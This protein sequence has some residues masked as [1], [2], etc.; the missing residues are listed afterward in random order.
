METSF[1]DYPFQSVAHRP[2]FLEGQGEAIDWCACGFGWLYAFNQEEAARCFCAAAAAQDDMAIAWW[3]IAITNGPFMNLPWDWFTAAE[4]AKALAVCHAALQKALERCAPPPKAVHGLIEALA[5]RFPSPVLPSENRLAEWER[6]YA[7]AMIG[8]Y[9]QFGADPDIATLYIDSQIMLT[10]WALYDVDRQAPNPDGRAASIHHALDIALGRDKHYCVDSAHVGLLHYDIHVHEMSPWPERSLTSAQRLEN[11]AA[12]DAGH[13][14]HMPSHIYALLG[15]YE[16]AA[17]CSRL[18]VATD[19]AFLP[20][21]SH[22]PFYRTLLCHD[23]HMLMFAGMQMGNRADATRGAAI[24]TDL[25]QDVLDEPPA[26]HM[27]MTLEGYLSTVSHVDIRFGRWHEVL[28]RV[29]D[30]DTA[31][32]PVSWAMHN[33]ARAVASA[34]LGLFD[35]A[36]QAA[37]AFDD[38]RSA[39]PAEHAFFN[40]PADAVL[41]VADLMMRGEMAYHA[42]EI[43]TAFELLYQAAAAEDRLGYNEPR[44]WMHPP[45]HALGALLLEQGR[46]AEALQVYEC[47]L[48]RNNDLPISRQNRGNIWSLAGR[49]EC[50]HRLEDSEMAAADANLAAAAGHADQTISSSCFCRGRVTATSKD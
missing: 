40:N 7:D 34:A 50:L 39:V 11:L 19:K 9:K 49:V 4:K 44:A 8:V 17:R 36:R 28:D 42:G 35:S 12:K 38:A 18:A 5:Q 31:S 15:D 3:G 32:R 41:A 25:L 21:L 6:N 2:A 22:A 10:P 20:A 24:I 27:V 37:E 30:G 23:A 14:Q 1:K 45:R 48:G 47:D 16:G 33:Y 43:E 29:F 13:L 46:V 26:T